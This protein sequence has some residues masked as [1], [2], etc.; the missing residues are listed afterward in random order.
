V[1]ASGRTIATQ[2]SRDG[3]VSIRAKVTGLLKAW[4]GGDQGGAGQLADQL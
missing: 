4:S 1:G 3:V 2:Q